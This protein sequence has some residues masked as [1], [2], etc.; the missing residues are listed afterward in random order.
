MLKNFF[1]VAMGG[2]IGAMLR[3]AVSLISKPGIGFPV[4]TFIINITGSFLIGII[5][6][7]SLRATG[8]I[9][10]NSKLFWATGICGGFT[11][12]SAFSYENLQL[13]QSAKS[14]LAFIYIILSVLL[15]ITASWFGFKLLQS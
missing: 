10:E 5:M 2:G 9:S 4:T 13:F 8:A 15:G 1:L 3:Y 12:F 11:T 14:N 6:A 7:L